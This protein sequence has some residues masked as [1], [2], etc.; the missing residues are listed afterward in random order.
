M[1]GVYNP[2][3]IG[4]RLQHELCYERLDCITVEGAAHLGQSIAAA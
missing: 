2:V 3:N 4:E 1:L